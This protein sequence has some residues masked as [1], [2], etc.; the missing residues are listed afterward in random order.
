M[1]NT[2]GLLLAAANSNVFR[3]TLIF[4]T[5]LY[6]TI[7]HVDCDPQNLTTVL[8]RVCEVTRMMDSIDGQENLMIG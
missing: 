6:S 4:Q 7:P 3:T 2:V 8:G 5:L 1:L